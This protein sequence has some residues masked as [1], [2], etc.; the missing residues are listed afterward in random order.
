MLNHE[1]RN[2]GIG[3]SEIAAILGLDSY[4]SPLDVWREKKGL[5]E[6][7]QG[8]Q[9]TVRGQRFEPIVA[10]YLQD[11]LDENYEG[12]FVVS[13]SEAHKEV[14]PSGAYRIDSEKDTLIHPTITHFVGSPDRY[15][16]MSDGELAGAELKTTLGNVRSYEDVC[17]KHI[18]WLLQAQYYMMLTGRKRWFLAWICA[19]FDFYCVELSH[20]QEMENY[21]ISQINS[22]WENHVIANN[23]PDPA[24]YSDVLKAYRP[25]KGGELQ[26]TYETIELL[27]EYRELSDSEKQIQARKLELKNMLSCIFGD[28][29][30]LSAGETYLATFKEQKTNRVDTDLL[31]SEYPEIYAKVTKTTISRVL[32]LKKHER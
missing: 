5:D 26:A 20:N 19:P 30:V 21:I 22:F 1:V 7:F 13:P 2:K 15:V 29:D 24:N 8:N 18:S 6:S 25:P 9:H 28:F 16:T 27:N 32:R 17:E 4:R 14:N 31:K 12:A 11:W 23:P 3:G 10:D